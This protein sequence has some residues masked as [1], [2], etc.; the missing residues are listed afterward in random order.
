MPVIGHGSN[1]DEGIQDFI[2]IGID[3]TFRGHPENTFRIIGNAIYDGLDQ[4]WSGVVVKSR[5]RATGCRHCPPISPLTLPR[6]LFLTI[7]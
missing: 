3:A 7:V 6:P 5:R 1:G 4:D 2:L